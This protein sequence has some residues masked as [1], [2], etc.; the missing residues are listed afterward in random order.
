MADRY[1]WTSADG[2]SVI[3]LTDQSAGFSVLAN[4]TRGLRSPGYSFATEDYAGMDGS[5]VQSVRATANT[6]TIGLLLEAASADEFAGRAQGLI[7]AMRPKA[8]PGTL[9]VA[10]SDGTSRS[11]AC[12]VTEGLEGDEA[13][14]VTLPGAWWKLLLKFYAPDPWWYGDA[15]DFPFLLGPPPAFFP[16]FPLRFAPSEIAGSIP[17]ENVG[18]EDAYPVWSVTGPGSGL[19]LTNNTTGKSISLSTTLVAGETLT[20]D[21]RPFFQSVVKGDGTNLFGDL[22][23]D[24]A[25]WVLQP[26]TNDISVLLTGATTDSRV[27]GSYR[28]RYAG[29]T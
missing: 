23:T 9:T 17:V 5:V 3:D 16:I 24:P 4:G 14:D 12:F 7:R 22:E 10:R 15:V 25:M 29:I 27:T 21:T 6:P 26:G 18:D 11:L 2:A 20:I 19:T 1:V 28:P 13:V 8:G